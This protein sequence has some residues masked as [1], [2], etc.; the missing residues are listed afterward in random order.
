[1]TKVDIEAVRKADIAFMR[2]ALKIATENGSD[3]AASPIGCVI[4]MDRRIIAAQR[5]HVAEKHD[6]VAH[7]EIEAIRTAGR[8]F[9]NGELRG[10]T[11]YSTLQPCGMC[12]MASIW[13]KVGRIV[14][15]AG[16]EDVHQ[17]YFEARHVDTL[18]FVKNAYRDDLVIEGGLLREDC[19]KLYYRPWDDVPLAE[20][21]NK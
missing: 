2:E 16:R 4:V 10:A 11:L 20:Q 5:N 6:A 14:Y 15:G 9:D 12:T 21:G 18:N 17:M 1:M 19:S 13:S 7:A 8:H 3:P